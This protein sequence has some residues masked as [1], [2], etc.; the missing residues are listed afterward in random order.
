MTWDG[1]LRAGSAAVFFVTFGAFFAVLIVIDIFLNIT[2]Y[3]RDDVVHV[4][5]VVATAL[6]AIARKLIVFDF[7]K[8]DGIEILCT[9]AVVLGPFPG[10]RD[11]PGRQ[12][13]RRVAGLRPVYQHRRMPCAPTRSVIAHSKYRVFQ[14]IIW[15]AVRHCD[16]EGLRAEANT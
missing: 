14:R 16:Q 12:E 7:M 4:K 9:G 6:M 5:L 13:I 8:I 10:W 1:D 2:L 11:C 15:T 3:L